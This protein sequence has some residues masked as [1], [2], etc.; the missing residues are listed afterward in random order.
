VT[1][2]G[3][4]KTADDTYGINFEQASFEYKGLHSTTGKGYWEQVHMS[5]YEASGA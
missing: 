5:D 1:I 2:Q 3:K 4:F